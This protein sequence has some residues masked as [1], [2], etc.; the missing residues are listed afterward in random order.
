[1]TRT[2]SGQSQPTKLPVTALETDQS[3]PR[4]QLNTYNPQLT[5]NILRTCNSKTDYASQ[6]LDKNKRKALKNDKT[7]FSAIM[8]MTDYHEKWTH[9]VM[10]NIPTLGPDLTS[11]LQH[12]LINIK[13]NYK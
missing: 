1:M 2:I 6:E 7:H 13:L 3:A 11:T 4:T 8:G 10:A 5:N 9:L 12:R